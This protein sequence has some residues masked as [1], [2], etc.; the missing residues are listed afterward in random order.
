MSDPN[1]RV[2]IGWR[3]WVAL[4]DLGIPRIKAKVDTGARTSSL[5][6]ADVEL[7]RVD[8][9]DRV[10]FV[11]MPRQRRDHPRVRAEADLVDVR[12]VRSS[13]GIWQER[14]TIRTRFRLGETE[15]TGEITLAA[16]DSMRFRMLLG[17]TCLAG[18]F[19]VDPGASYVAGRP[20]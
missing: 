3:E 12:R 7:L 1:N 19:L 14:P 10:R 5:Q 20:G 6:A 2:L 4:P 9:V 16:R 18:S 15:W 11:V 17:R 8:G 13:N